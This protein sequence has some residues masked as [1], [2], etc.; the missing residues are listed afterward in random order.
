MANKMLYYF[1]TACIIVVVVAVMWTVVSQSVICKYL[2]IEESGKT[3]TILGKIVVVHFC[4]INAWYAEAGGSV[5][6]SSHT[7]YQLGSPT[8]QVTLD[9]GWLVPSK[10]EPVQDF[11]R[12]CPQNLPK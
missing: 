11:F 5:S 12:D 7:Y 10:V 8:V 1:V 9:R 3:P 6:P 2:W 4:Q